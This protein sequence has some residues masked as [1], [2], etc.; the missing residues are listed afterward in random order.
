MKID[1]ILELIDSDS[2]LDKNNLDNESLKTPKLHAKYYRI[3]ME[4]IRILKSLD[5]KYNQVKKDR[6]SYYLGDLPDEV[7]KEE[8][9]HKKWL[10]SEIDIALKADEKLNEI[11]VK[12]DLQKMKVKLIEDFIKT[13]NNRSF[14]IRDAIEFAKFKNG[15]Y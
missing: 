15:G 9:L 1:E 14:I 4:E 10:K 5:I 13:L 7:Y 3:F 6:Q 2:E 11:D 12:R 8:P